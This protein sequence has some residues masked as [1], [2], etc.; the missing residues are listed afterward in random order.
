MPTS[1]KE[2]HVADVLRTDGKDILRWKDGTPIDSELFDQDGIDKYIDAVQEGRIGK[3]TIAA[4][5]A[6][7]DWQLE[8]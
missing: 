6:D 1:D 2:L 8:D 7:L 4:V 5:L 3:E